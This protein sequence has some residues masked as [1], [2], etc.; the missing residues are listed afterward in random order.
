MEKIKNKVHSI[1]YKLLMERK[2]SITAYI[3]QQ[4][5][6]KAAI[7]DN[8]GSDEANNLMRDVFERKAAIKECTKEIKAHKD[9]LK[10]CSSHTDG[11]ET[12]PYFKSLMGYANAIGEGY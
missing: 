1:A 3:A 2:D 11:L 12:S 4:K 9:F 8:W 6:D 7:N 10:K 5:I